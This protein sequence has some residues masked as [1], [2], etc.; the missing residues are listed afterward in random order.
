LNNVVIA[1][2]SSNHRYTSEKEYSKAAHVAMFRAI[3]E[4]IK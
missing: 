2:T 4:S 3:V 1:K